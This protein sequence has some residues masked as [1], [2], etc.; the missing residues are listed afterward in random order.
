MAAVSRWP[1]TG[2]AAALVVDSAVVVVIPASL[3]RHTGRVTR[4]RVALTCPVLPGE[5]L[6]NGLAV[7][8]VS[9]SRS[10]ARSTYRQEYNNKLAERDK[11]QGELNDD[12]KKSPLKRCRPLSENQ[13]GQAR[14]G[15]RRS[16]PYPARSGQGRGRRA[17][18]KR[19]RP[20]S[21]NA[22]ATAS[23]VRTRPH[24][25]LAVVFMGGLSQSP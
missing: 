6:M 4:P 2:L 1:V 20:A 10:N 16:G 7:P 21:R 5:S 18:S 23:P 12:L 15:Q 8:S 22:K 25:G 19:T 9:A 17:G 11:L 14:Q 24:A 13:A 3:A